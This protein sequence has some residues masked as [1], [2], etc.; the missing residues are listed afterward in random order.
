[1]DY[2]THIRF[3]THLQNDLFW[4]Q[5]PY[6]I[7]GVEKKQQEERVSVATRNSCG[8]TIRYDSNFKNTEGEKTLASRKALVFIAKYN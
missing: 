1:M 3:K 5:A 7:R 6:H 4:G 2:G 8:V